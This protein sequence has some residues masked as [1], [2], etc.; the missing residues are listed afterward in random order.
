MFH[1]QKF[2]AQIRSNF[3]INTYV[4]LIFA[5]KYLNL[6]PFYTNCYKYRFTNMETVNHNK[7]GVTEKPKE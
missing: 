5:T 4:I 6:C 1:N 7:Q 3:M 2:Y